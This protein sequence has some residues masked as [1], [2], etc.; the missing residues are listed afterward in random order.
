MAAAIEKGTNAVSWVVA[1]QC[2]TQ[3][4]SLELVEVVS[5]VVHCYSRASLVACPQLGKRVS[6]SVRADTQRCNGL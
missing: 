4:L 3:L 6:Y 1:A 2:P 5:D